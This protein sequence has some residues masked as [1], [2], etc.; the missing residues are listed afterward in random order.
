[1]NNELFEPSIPDDHKPSKSY[2]ISYLFY[3]AFFGGLIPTMVLC[4]RN[5][6]WLYIK[7]KTIHKLIAAGIILLVFKI[8]LMGYFM[9]GMEGGLQ[10]GEVLGQSKR[11]MR[12]ASKI[13]AVLLYLGY[14]MVMKK[15]FTRHI[16]TGG[17]TE[18]LLSEAIIWILTGGILENI[19]MFVGGLFARNIF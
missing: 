6:A 10:L 1:M 12:I 17:E 4:S 9:S 3:S 15:A 8:F 18:P 7:E 11:L 2:N 13:M 16:A 19:I 5:A 14:Y